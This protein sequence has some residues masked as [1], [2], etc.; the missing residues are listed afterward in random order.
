MNTMVFFLEEPSAREML[1]GILPK[2]LPSD[3][4]CRFVVFQGKQDLEKNLTRRIN[5]WLTPNSAF[6]IMRDQDSGDCKDIKQRLLTLS[7]SRF[8]VLVRI[9]CRELESFYLG[10]LAAVEAA[11]GLTG[12][13]SKQE[14]VKYRDPD[15]LENAAEELKVLTK[16]KYQKISGS[17]SIGP[18]LSLT[19]NRSRSFLALVQGLK[20]LSE[21][22]F[23][24]R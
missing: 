19:T 23:A 15:Q 14:K 7:Q 9:A 6:V 12:V 18:H 20:D 21:S 2:I 13:A 11:L 10:D 5:G 24:S 1:Q 8:P 3:I 17:R 22:S 16:Y 4:Q